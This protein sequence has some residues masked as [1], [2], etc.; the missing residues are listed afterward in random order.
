MP[1]IPAASSHASARSF[2][3]EVVGRQPAEGHPE[4][5]VLDLSADGHA[6]LGHEHGPVRRSWTARTEPVVWTRLLKAVEDM[7][8]GSPAQEPSDG[9]PVHRSLQVLDA[10]QTR[11]VAWDGGTASLRAAALLDSLVA[12]ISG[13]ASDLVANTLPPLIHRLT[14]EPADDPRGH[15]PTA[16]FGQVGGQDAFAVARTSGGFGLYA[17][18][19]LKL[20]AETA[21]QGQLHRALVLGS[22][23]TR[24]L[25]VTS[26]QDNAVWAWDLTGSDGLVH[27]RVGHSGPVGAV[28]FPADPEGELVYS[29]GADGNVWAW[30]AED[31]KEV[32]ALTGHEH[33]VNALAGGRVGDLDLLVSGGDDGTVRVRDTATGG[34]MGSITPG[35]EWINAVAFTGSEGR[36][37]VAATGSDHVIR[38]WDLA[39]DKPTRRLSGHTA[40]VTGLAFLGLANRAVLASCS[41]DGTIRTW[42]AETGDALDTWPAQDA[43]PAAL[44]AVPSPGGPLLLSGGATGTVRVWDAHGTEVRALATDHGPV[45]ALAAAEID[46]VPV[47]AVG[48]L[49]GSLGVWDVATGS[50]RQVLAP[51]DGPV[52][53]VCFSPAGDRIVCGTSR[54]TVRVHGADDGALR[55][56]PTPHTDAVAA[57][58]FLPVAGG[59]VASAG[60]DRTVRTWEAAT[61]TPLLRLRGHEAP[62]TLL[63]AGQAGTDPVLAS[64]DEDGALLVWDA[65]SGRRLLDLRTTR[66]LTAL[67]FGTVD[68][69]DILV[70][71]EQD[72]PV[73]VWEPASGE[74]LVAVDHD[75]SEVTVL[76]VRAFYE[77]TVLLIG[78][79]DG[80]V[81]TRRL[82]DGADM[83]AADVTLT[84]LALSFAPPETL[85]VAGVDGLTTVPFTPEVVGNGAG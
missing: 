33:M 57:L 21:D 38:V 24:D 66:P 67:A 18:E 52:T 60:A 6:R 42:D 22:D 85:L 79:R 47:A 63:A 5:F 36:G 62:V 50:V 78:T 30:G 77:I 9:E 16:V 71:A 20:L 37:L 31:G 17:V 65:L 46:G 68:G 59:L 12:Q 32:G 8:A 23:G 58:A 74:E 10:S 15:E 53:S 84:P 56:V 75:G 82:P 45:Q 51:D 3:Y 11:T 35:T 76:A 40:A 27:A 54:G 2:R 49:D 14:G 72:G 1:P 28:A 69:V 34:S 55:L 70:G 29:G 19:P 64:A 26:G 43:W 73:R 25:L 44:A 13:P 81:R 7:P 83:G 39:A 48:S 80:E 61:G 4:H 41:Y